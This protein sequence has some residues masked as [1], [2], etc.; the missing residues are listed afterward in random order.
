MKIFD[1][2]GKHQ[3]NAN[4][5][6]VVEVVVDKSKGVPEFKLKNNLKKENEPEQESNLYRTPYLVVRDF[7]KNGVNVG[8]PL[9]TFLPNLG[10]GNVIKLGRV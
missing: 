10:P 3:D 6:F 1:V 7:C 8:Y 9:R 2:N 4:N 5:S